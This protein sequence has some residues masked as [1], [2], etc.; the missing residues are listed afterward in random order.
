M[1]FYFSFLSL[2]V[3]VR[4]FFSCVMMMNWWWTV[5]VVWLTDERLITLFPA[6]IIV[7]DP[8]HRESL[9]HRKQ[10]WTCAE[11]KFRLCWMKLCSS[12]NHYTTAPLMI[13]TTPRRSGPYLFGT[14]Q[15]Y[16][17]SRMDLLRQTFVELSTSSFPLGWTF[18]V[19]HINI[20]VS[21]DSLSSILG[22]ST[23]SLSLW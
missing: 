5:F 1:F 19:L 12:D 18:G 15:S 8:H 23:G 13:T 16:F 9:T 14:K 11:S 2:S 4:L 7:R 22:F 6:G 20:L 21:F 10:D 3:F 17:L